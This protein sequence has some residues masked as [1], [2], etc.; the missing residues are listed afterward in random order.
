[1]LDNVSF[2]KPNHYLLRK[3][4]FTLVD[5]HLHSNYSDGSAKVYS[6]IKKAKKLGIGLAL[7]DHNE[8]AGVLKAWKNLSDVLIIPGMEF[9]CSEGFHVLIY[10]YSL[11]ELEEFYINHVK[12]N[13]SPHPYMLTKLSFNDLIVCLEKYNYVISAAHPFSPT[14]MGLF[15]NIKRGYIED[16]VLR[17]VHSFEV[18]AGSHSRK[19]NYNTIKWA[20]QMNKSVTGGSDAHTLIDIGNTVTYSSGSN[21]DSFLD[22]IIS[23]DNFVV[24]RE[25]KKPNKMLQYAVTVKKHM[26]YLRPAIKLRY[27]TAIKTPIKHYGPRIKEKIKSKINGNH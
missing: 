12:K 20:W 7:T 4:G 17:D 21:V 15:T 23:K 22:N 9:T 16:N 24:G 26:K 19:M 10:F 2:G 13:K 11:R 5:M 1:M 8:V 14:R 6:L 3:Q 18:I 27:D 25:Q